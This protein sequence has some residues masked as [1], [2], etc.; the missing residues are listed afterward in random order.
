MVAAAQEPVDQSNMLLYEEVT[1][2][3][4]DAV[5]MEGGEV[6]RNVPATANVVHQMH[7]AHSAT[8]SMQVW[9]RCKSNQQE[10]QTR[11]QKCAGSTW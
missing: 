6:A 3:P 10:Q 5:P 8:V 7:V 2:A 9:L 11:M 4:E 1:N